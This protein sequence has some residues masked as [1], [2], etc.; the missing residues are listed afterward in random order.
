MKNWLR[1]V[2]LLVGLWA[3]GSKEERMAER[4]AN[5]TPVRLVRL[6]IA[7]FASPL[8]NTS[9]LDSIKN[10]LPHAYKDYF[11]GVL[12]LGDPD[13]EDFVLEL[14][15]FRSD[16]YMRQLYEKARALYG[17]D[18][19]PFQELKKGLA[20]YHFYFPSRPLPTLVVC[21]SALNYAAAANDSTLFVGIDMYLGP[22]FEAY[23][24][25]HMPAYIR[26]RRKSEYLTAEALRAWLITE[27]P[28]PSATP[29]FAENLIYHGRLMCILEK[30]LP[31]QE[32]YLLVGYTKE[33]EKFCRQNIRNI[34]QYF[35]D[36]GILQSRENRDLARYFEEAPFSY[37]MPR[38]TPGRTGVWIGWQIVRQFRKKH[39]D[40]TLDSLMKINDLQSIFL[41]SGFRP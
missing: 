8:N 15:G 37:G 16:Y 7:L 41:R 22:D 38:E 11:Q 32:D 25:M 34:W 27:F 17:T 30:I 33:Q 12:R 20:R 31:N 40:I 2:I 14:A 1:I 39:P 28:P 18:E 23:L 3:C 5:N 35:V 24:A 29:T 4:A 10:A 19:T 13:R 21:L 26:Q 36:A 9:L 6:D